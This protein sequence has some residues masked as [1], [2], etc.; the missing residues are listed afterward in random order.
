LQYD[1]VIFVVEPSEPAKAAI[2][3]YV[4]LFDYGFLIAE[5]GALP[6]SAPGFSAPLSRFTVP[7]GYRPRGSRMLQYKGWHGGGSRA[8]RY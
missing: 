1:K 5:R 6:P 3:K 2:G 4:T 7:E 8:R